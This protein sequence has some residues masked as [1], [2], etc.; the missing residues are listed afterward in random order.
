M[1]Q[2]NADASASSATTQV[3]LGVTGFRNNSGL[4]VVSSLSFNMMY[5][6]C[7]GDCVQGVL[8]V[9]VD[10]KFFAQPFPFGVGVDTKG[11]L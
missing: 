4:G 5:L 1:P 11:V 9:L 7:A 2:S 3:S 6:V 10:F 8:F